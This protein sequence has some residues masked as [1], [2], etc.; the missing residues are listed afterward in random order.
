MLQATV[1]F[2]RFFLKIKSEFG[3]VRKNK[4][5]LIMEQSLH[6]GFLIYICIWTY[7]YVLGYIYIIYMERERM[8]C[9]KWAS[10]LLSHD[11][12]MGILYKYVY[13]IGGTQ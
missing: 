8:L 5:G 3:I 9:S 13:G 10:H 6:T 2:K 4:Y 12:K 7:I 1:K 11:Y